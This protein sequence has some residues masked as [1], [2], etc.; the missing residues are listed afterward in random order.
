MKIINISTAKP[1][2]IILESGALS[3]V[4]E[5]MA[6]RFPAPRK[7]CVVTD[8]NVGAL[9][10]EQVLTGLKDAGFDTFRVSFPAGEHSKSLSTYMNLMESLAE[11]GITKGDILLALGGGIVG[12]VT[13]FVAGTYMYPCPPHSLLI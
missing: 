3:K 4:G 2:D 1:Y 12:D 8:S 10:G 5:Y 6:E 9:Y 11:E 13:G 7:I